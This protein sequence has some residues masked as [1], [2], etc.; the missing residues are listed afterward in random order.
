MKNYKPLFGLFTLLL[1]LTLIFGQATAQKSMTDSTETLEG[2]VVDAST[3]KPLANVVVEIPQL[4]QEVRT[5]EEGKF[6]FTGIPLVNALTIKIDHSGYKA[7]SKTIQSDQ[8]NGSLT[9]E[10]Q[11][12]S[13]K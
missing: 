2:K 1:G 10:L 4:N 8:Q 11:P 12:K 5:D 3:S 7:F 9:L 13:G 6:T